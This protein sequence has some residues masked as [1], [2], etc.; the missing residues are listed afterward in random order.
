MD[1]LAP[2]NLVPRYITI[3]C[4]DELQ[5]PPNQEPS[6]PDI[7]SPQLGPQDEPEGWLNG[8]WVGLN[9]RGHTKLSGTKDAGTAANRALQ[10]YK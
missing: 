4:Y 7:P 10:G 9:R 8:K 2:Y 1:I 5:Q 6:T 3:P